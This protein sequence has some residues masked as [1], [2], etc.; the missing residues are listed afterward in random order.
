MENF[1]S[2]LHL[3][4]KYHTLLGYSALSL[5]AA[6]GENAFSSIVYK[7]P[8]NSWNRMYGL[9][10]L[11]VPALV[12][13]L[14]GFLLSENMWRYLT[15]CCFSSK[16]I[17]SGKKGFRCLCILWKV[18]F[19]SSLAPII[20]IAL[21]LLNGSF[22]EC[23][24]TGT[25]WKFT[26]EMLCQNMS[27]TCE[28]ELHLVPCAKVL[29]LSLTEEQVDV[30]LR[31]ISAQSQM[32][33]WILVT[34]LVFLAVFSTCVSQCASP[35]SYHQLKFWKKYIQKEEELLDKRA[36]EYATKLAER[37]LKSF[38]EHTK[39]EPFQTPSNKEWQQISSAYSFSRNGPYYS[40]LHKYVELHKRD[41][42]CRFSGGD[43]TLPVD[44]NLIGADIES[45]F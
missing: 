6:F 18:T 45:G 43:Y 26:K 10:F 31:A 33:G 44:L 25:Q 41:E 29:T 9:V 20:W 24:A 37:N 21:A 11:L 36:N 28:E 27:Q 39:P 23:I 4:V 16:L 22:S 14:L 8:C 15:G 42:S 17:C 32:A 1:R 2:V 40:T 35:I 7:C 38:F 3:S 30:V 5:L 34:C 19:L 12:L 13:F